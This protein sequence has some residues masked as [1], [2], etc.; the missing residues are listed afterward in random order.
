MDRAGAVIEHVA[1]DMSPAY[2]SSVLENAPCAIHVYDHF[3]VVK[4]MN[5]ALS[6]LRTKMYEQERKTSRK[7]VIMGTRWLLLRNSEDITDK[8]DKRKLER[9][10]KV[11][12]PLAKAYYLKESLRQIWMQP[13]KQMAETELD[14]WVRQAWETGIP[15]ITRVANSIAG[16]RTAILAWYD[17]HF[18]TGKVEGINNKI[19]VLKRVAYGFRD[20]EYFKLRLFALHEQRITA[21][22]G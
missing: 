1:T 10:L 7:K 21:F 4:M 2:T 11:N 6:K 13:N 18:S 15:L 9:A 19:K 17:C 22:L 14:C 16:H 8:R 5:E 3:H 20:D 12:E